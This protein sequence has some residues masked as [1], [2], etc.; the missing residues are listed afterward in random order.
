MKQGNGR[1]KDD[2]GQKYG[3][4]GAEARQE[5]RA[6]MSG[7]R[8]HEEGG[9]GREGVSIIARGRRSVV[10]SAPRIR[11]PVPGRYRTG[12]DQAGRPCLYQG[13]SAVSVW[14]SCRVKMVN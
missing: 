10:V 11:T 9:L 14:R 2:G 5:V 3:W 4:G 7:L 6:G 8:T 12:V 1:G 13:Q